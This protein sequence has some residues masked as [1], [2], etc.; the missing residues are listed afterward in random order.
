MR[1]S[2]PVKT[3][4]NTFRQPTGWAILTSLGIH[5]IVGVSVDSLPILPK[6]AKQPTIVGRIELTPEQL[7]IVEEPPRSKL[8]LPALPKK[9]TTEPLNVPSSPPAETAESSV[10]T[11]PENLDSLRPITNPGAIISKS[12]SQPENST[13][14]GSSSLPINNN[15]RTQP[16]ISPTQISPNPW[17]PQPQPQPQPINNNPWSA[18]PQPQTNPNPW[19]AQPQPQ[20]NPNPW[21]AQPQPQTNPNPWSAQ[22]QP[23]AN[24][25]PWRPQPQQP[26]NNN[27]WPPQ[28]QQ[29][30]NNNPWPPQ[31]Q[32]PINNNPWPPQPQQPINNNSWLPNNYPGTG[33]NYIHNS[34]VDGD[35]NT[36]GGLANPNGRDELAYRQEP[37][38]FEINVPAPAPENFGPDTLPERGQDQGINDRVAVLLADIRSKK[39]LKYSSSR[40][41]KQWATMRFDSWFNHSK[42]VAEKLDLALPSPETKNLDYP[43]EACDVDLKGNQTVA[44]AVLID[45][46][47]EIAYGPEE[48]QSSGYSLLNRLALESIKDSQF[49]ATGEYKAYSYRIKFNPNSKTCSG[50]EF[51]ERTIQSGSED[52]LPPGIVEP[53]IEALDSRKN[54]Y[55]ERLLKKPGSGGNPDSGTTAPDAYGEGYDSESDLFKINEPDSGDNPDSGTT[56]PDAYGEGDESESDLFKID[57]EP[58]SEDNPESGKLKIDEAGSGDRPDSGRTAPDALES[59][60]NDDL[61]SFKKI[62]EPDSGDNSD[63]ETLKTREPG[64][65]ENPNPE[66]TVPYA[67]GEAKDPGLGEDS[68]PAIPESGVDASGEAKDPGLGE[69][70]APAIPESGVDASG[71]AKDPG[72]G[73]DSAPAI[74]ESGVDA[75]DLGE[76]SAPA[77]PE[78]EI[79]DSGLGDEEDPEVTAP[80]APGEAK[81]PGLAED[82]APAVPESEVEDTG[83]GD[84]EAPEVTAPDAPGEVEDIA[85]AVPE[86][87]VEDPGLGDE[88]A[89]EVTAPAAPG[90]SISA[91]EESPQTPGRRDGLPGFLD[92]DFP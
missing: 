14:I 87:E 88:E 56:A 10:T 58:D 27:P 36:A 73:E 64:S 26:I 49:E 23:Q 19:S 47:G 51:V 72:L 85:P 70:S 41:S 60:D 78:S 1:Y 42:K 61:E 66:V 67:P 6:K 71:E 84:E 39:D 33:D 34:D 57:D 89:P 55:L 79:E 22:P 20:T 90:T 68:A 35:L 69:D 50:S 32:Q 9:L 15:S 40:T 8:S 29:P 31:P 80:D 2:L 3:L 92:S 76:K 24:P 5:G 45:P 12:I 37:P 75:S 44:V 77:R 59:G 62:E 83:L 65:G 43:P 17:S 11:I 13:S 30:I 25:S 48:I 21:S 28:P 63:S 7:G 46:K 16:Q 86:S 38:Q 52:R 54:P 81:D 91:D 74:P 82:L 4:F 18:Q 53:E